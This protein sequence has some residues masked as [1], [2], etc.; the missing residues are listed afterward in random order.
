MLYDGPFYFEVAAFVLEPLW[1]GVCSVVGRCVFALFSL[2]KHTLQFAQIPTNFTNFPSLH[3][4]GIAATFTYQNISYHRFP[5][6]RR[7]RWQQSAPTS[8]SK[9]AIDF[10]ITTAIVSPTTTA[11]A[12]S[13]TTAFIIS[14]NT[15]AAVSSHQTGWD[16]S[17]GRPSQ[18]T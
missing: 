4:S 3:G 14:T 12:V 17:Q 15:A 2:S 11:I 18:L 8:P 13:F 1:A 6:H 7:L 5:F 10:S 16:E 9:A